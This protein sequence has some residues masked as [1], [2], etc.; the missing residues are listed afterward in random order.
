MT[1]PAS[2]PSPSFSERV[3]SRLSTGLFGNRSSRRGFL[4]STAVVGSALTTKPWKYLV[5]PVSAYDAV[6]GSGNECGDGWTVFCCTLSKQNMC[7]NDTFVG[8]WWKAD[9]SGFC[10]GGARYYIDCN[11]KCGSIWNGS[12]HCNN[13]GTCDRRRVACNQFRYGQCHQEISCYGPVVCR[14]ATCTPPWQYDQTCT[15]ASATDNNTATH[16]APCLDR[17]CSAITDLWHHY[18]GPTGVLGQMTIPPGPDPSGRGLWAVFQHGAIFESATTGTHAVR[19]SIWGEYYGQRNTLSPLGFPI[20]E[21]S[22]LT[23][24]WGKVFVSWFEQ[25]VIVASWTAGVHSVWQPIYQCYWGIGSVK[26]ALGHPTDSVQP[27]SDGGQWQP[28]QDGLI[29][30]SSGTGAH[31]IRGSLSLKYRVLGREKSSLGYP[32]SNTGTVRGVAVCWFQDGMISDSHDVGLHAIWGPIY[33]KYYGMGSYTSPLGFPISDVYTQSDGTQRADFQHG[34]LTYN[35]LTGI[36][37]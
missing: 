15:T 13:T 31:E 28:F 35:P 17:G 12:C 27:T 9:N 19:G 8:G 3:V 26:S 32:I 29:Y 5:E 24:P 2:T 6:C 20:T 14:V 16:S 36:V 4:A 30:W 10:C 11:A 22:T 34:S 7:P 23:T 1:A 37:S 25:G 21:E 33:R 18:G